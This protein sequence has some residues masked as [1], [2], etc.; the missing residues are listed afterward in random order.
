MADE[1]DRLINIPKPERTIGFRANA[2]P[3][4]VFRFAMPDGSYLDVDAEVALAA[5]NTKA[6]LDAEYVR[7]LLNLGGHY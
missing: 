3:Y 5:K 2:H 7:N 4:Q 1:G 6:F